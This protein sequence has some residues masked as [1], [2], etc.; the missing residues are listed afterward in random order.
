MMVRVLLFASL[1]ERAGWA[2]RVIDVP[3]GATL[4]SIWETLRI[5]LPV[6]P[7]AACERAWAPWDAAVPENAEVA[8]VPPVSGG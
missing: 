8:F 1:A 5:D 3:E 7:L 4:L 6:R 2:E